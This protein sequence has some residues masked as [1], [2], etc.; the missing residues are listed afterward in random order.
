M[1]LLANHSALF[2]IVIDVIILKM[3]KTTNHGTFNI[4]IDTLQI[5]YNEFFL[6]CFLQ[7]LKERKVKKERQD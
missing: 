1:K 4:V 7:N 3:N 2:S 5:I 6:C